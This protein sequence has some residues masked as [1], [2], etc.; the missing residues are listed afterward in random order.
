MDTDGRFARWLR[1][2][3]HAGN[4]WGSLYLL[5]TIAIMVGVGAWPATQGEPIRVWWIF[6]VGALGAF[7]IC[8]PWI[9]EALDRR[10]VHWVAA[11]ER[12]NK[13]RKIEANPWFYNRLDEKHKTD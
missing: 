8:R 4:M 11:R 2:P 12:E 7:L 6:P 5:P 10:A 13:R 1:K 9:M 3:A